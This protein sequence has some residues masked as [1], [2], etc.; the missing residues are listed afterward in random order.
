MAY[1]MVRSVVALSSMFLAYSL[2]SARFSSLRNLPNGGCQT[3]LL[4]GLAMRRIYLVAIWARD[5]IQHC[6]LSD[7]LRKRIPACVSIRG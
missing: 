6:D 1:H 2:D 5:M 3:Y 4:F 7:E